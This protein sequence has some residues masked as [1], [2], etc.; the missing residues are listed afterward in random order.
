MNETEAKAALTRAEKKSSEAQ[1]VSDKVVK[2]KSSGTFLVFSWVSV[3]AVSAGSN[4]TRPIKMND[5]SNSES[6]SLRRRTTSTSHST[7][8]EVHVVFD[9]DRDEPKKKNLF[10]CVSFLTS[11]LTS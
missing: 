3:S 6:G 2:I 9:V 10:P 4:V 1:N 7:G 8:K 11:K 5:K